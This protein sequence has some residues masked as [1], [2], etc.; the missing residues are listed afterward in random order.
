MAKSRRR[1][2]YPILLII[3]A[4]GLVFSGSMVPLAYW[5]FEDGPPVDV[6]AAG[7]AGWLIMALSVLGLAIMILG[8]VLLRAVPRIPAFLLGLFPAFVAGVGVLGAQIGLGNVF[9]A[10]GVAGADRIQVAA[11]GVFEALNASV[12]GAY[13]AAA[14]MMASALTISLRHWPSRGSLSSG[15]KVGLVGG[16]FLLIAMIIGSLFWTPLGGLG[17]LPWITAFADLV[18]IAVA[19][20]AIRNDPTDAANVQ[21]AGELWVTLLLSMGAI[22]WVVTARHTSA[23]MEGSMTLSASSPHLDPSKVIESWTA[24]GPA[25]Y[26]SALYVVPLLFAAV[27]SMLSRES[28]GSWGLRKAASSLL[29]VPLFFAVPA[30][31]QHLQTGSAAKRL[32]DVLSCAPAWLPRVQQTLPITKNAMESS[33]PEAVLEIGPSEIRLGDKNLGALSK[34]DSSD[35]CA[36]VSSQL[37]EFQGFFAVSSTLSYRRAACLIDALSQSPSF[38]GRSDMY[39]QRNPESSAGR[40][41]GV[42]FWLLQSEPRGEASARPPFDQLGTRLWQLTTFGPSAEGWDPRLVHLH[43]MENG[44]TLKRDPASTPMRFEG[45]AVDGLS[46]LQSVLGLNMA[47]QVMV[48][49][50]EGAVSMGQLLHYASAFR[51]PQLMMPAVEPSDNALPDD[52]DAGVGDGDSPE[53]IA[54]EAAATP[55]ASA[56]SAGS[57][58]SAVGPDR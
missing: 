12:I 4:N 2:I 46:K 51:D 33:C 32:A 20:H 36:A 55:A 50:A 16:A 43:V 18:A 27:M 47:A 8:G 6:A 26:A 28:L 37:V 29:F 24:A 7:F 39:R 52:K 48:L 14:L 1:S 38:R 57:A 35:G 40:A 22:V 54:P 9:E 30:V 49:S 25:L 23:L 17:V 5:G 21:A 58:S 45:S 10:V 31:L 3:L 15:G 56:S 53:A 19:A 44:W 34:L 11:L 42:V 41:G 13:V